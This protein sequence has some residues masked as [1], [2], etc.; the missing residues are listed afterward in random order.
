LP[1]VDV[2]IP[3]RSNAVLNDKASPLRN[4]N[5]G[6]IEEH[7]RMIWQKTRQYGRRN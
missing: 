6:E 5:I 3:P 2:I 4:R 7:V 1:D